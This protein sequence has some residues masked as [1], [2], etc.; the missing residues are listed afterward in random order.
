MAHWIEMEQGGGSVNYASLDIDSHGA[1]LRAKHLHLGTVTAS[2]L[3]C[4]ESACTST[5]A[6]CTRRTAS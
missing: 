6:V 4:L 5:V 3:A 2:Q 1:L